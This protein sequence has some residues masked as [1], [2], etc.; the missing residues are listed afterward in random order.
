MT[1][2]SSRPTVSIVVPAYNAEPF[3]ARALRSAVGQTYRNLEIV[4][5]DDGSTDSTAALIHGFKD[6]RIRYLHQ[7]NQGQGRARNRGIRT[8]TGAYI[9][10]L[11]ADDFYRADKIERQVA[12]LETHPEFGAAFCNALHFYSDAPER[13]FRRSS[14]IDAADIFRALMQSSLINPNTLMVRAPVLRDKFEFREDR[15]YPEEWDLYL[16]LSRAGVRFG[17]QD[18]D[19]AVVEIRENSNTTMEIQWILKRH[20][21]EMF[22]RLFADMSES[23]R[24]ALD[25]DGVLRRCKRNLAAAYLVAGNKTAFGEIAAELLSRP[26]ASLLQSV[27]NAVPTSILRRG[28]SH[29]W[30]WRQFRSFSRRPGPAADAGSKLPVL[31][32]KAGT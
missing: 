10:F 17:Y 13:L 7:A 14:R 27:V 25:A 2:H 1:D 3:I 21:L 18:E 32:S 15:Y 30:R 4:V 11:D 6:P 16:R 22:E 23:E 20:A 28:T 19:L 5:I 31:R 8:S 29:L 9:T 24:T 12:F 26:V